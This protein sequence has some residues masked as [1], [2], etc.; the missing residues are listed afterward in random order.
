M[1]RAQD[2]FYESVNEKWLKENPCP[3]DYSRWGTFEELNKVRF[4]LT[5]VKSGISSGLQFTFVDCL[6]EYKSRKNYIS[7][8]F[9]A[10]RRRL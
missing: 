9:Y 6:S 4:I 8:K 5:L 1:V 3:S 2:D 10:N 7:L